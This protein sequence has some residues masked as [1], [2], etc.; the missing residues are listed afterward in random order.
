MGASWNPKHDCARKEPRRKI[1]STTKL[2]TESPS[3][4]NG[5]FTSG[6]PKVVYVAFDVSAAFLQCDRTEV[7]GASLKAFGVKS[8]VI[9]LRAPMVCG[10]PG[11]VTELLKA[12]YGF[13]DAPRRWFLSADKELRRLG[14]EPAAADPAASV[15]RRGGRAS[16]IVCLHVDDVRVT[17]GGKG[18]QRAAEFMHRFSVS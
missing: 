7:G 8:R 15:L 18:L 11:F 12:P 13:A 16:S 9:F 17:G 1:P 4:K 10:R 3:S 5:A 6:G 14:F 2:F